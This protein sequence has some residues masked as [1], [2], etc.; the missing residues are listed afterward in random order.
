MVYTGVTL[1]PSEIVVLGLVML[2]SATSL[3]GLL[4]LFQHRLPTRTASET[5]KLHRVSR[6][7]A[8]PPSSDSLRSIRASVLSHHE[9]K[10]ARGAAA[11]VT[12]AKKLRYAGWRLPSLGYHALSAAISLGFCLVLGPRLDLFMLP[13]LVATGPVIMR[14]LLVRSIDRRTNRF[15]DDYPQFLMTVVALL[16]TGLTP[17]GALEVAAQELEPR[18]L[19]R[20]EVLLM[21]ERIRV[22]VPE[23]RSIG[24]LG[25]TIDHPEIELFVQCLLLGLRMGGSLSESLERLSKQVRKRQYFKRAAVASVSQQRGSMIAI[26]LIMAGLGV[27]ISTL[28]PKLVSGIYTQPIGWKV[29]QGCMLVMI[30]AVAWLKGITRLKI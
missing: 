3:F 20:Q 15:S 16:K 13:A 10:K 6:S 9:G 26:T 28:M 30:I 24:C 17:T 1:A 29:A 11:R 4:A 21:L 14:S 2:L 7:C 27:L 19:V 25:E 5:G 23:D 12:L 8:H 22:G 18:S